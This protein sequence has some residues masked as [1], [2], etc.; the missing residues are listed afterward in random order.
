MVSRALVTAL[1]SSRAGAFLRPGIDHRSVA[2]VKQSSH[3]R[4]STSSTPAD[5]HERPTFRPAGIN[6]PRRSGSPY[7][8]VAHLLHLVAA[9]VNSPASRPIARHAPQ[10]RQT[11]AETGIFDTDSIAWN[12][13]HGTRGGG[14]IALAQGKRQP[15]NSDRSSGGGILRKDGVDGAMERLRISPGKKFNRGPRDAQSWILRR[16][17]DDTIQEG[18]HLGIAS[19]EEVTDGKFLQHKQ[20]AWIQRESAI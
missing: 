13:R 3:L 12:V 18:S 2:R 16:E 4:L 11:S 1:S 10:L 20:I 19:Q 14:G 17:R 8:M 5:L 9:A 6:H 15:L 7:W